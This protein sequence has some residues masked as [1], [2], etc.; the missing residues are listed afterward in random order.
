M[1]YRD[2]VDTLYQRAIILQKE[3]DRSEERLA[4][5]EKELAGLRGERQFRE[6]T[7][8][9]LRALR[10][11][12]P[13]ETLLSR[14]VNTLTGRTEPPPEPR[15]ESLESSWLTPYHRRASALEAARDRLDKLDDETLAIVGAIIEEL[16]MEPERRDAVLCSLRPLVD[17]ITNAYDRRR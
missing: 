6:D 9:G 1:G 7:S 16:A 11:L 8:P 10:T 4:E 3:L 2:D 13:A 12:P 17:D 14:L 15:A 5:R